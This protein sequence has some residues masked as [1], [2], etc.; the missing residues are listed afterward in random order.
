MQGSCALSPMEIELAFRKESSEL[1]GS[2]GRPV[3]RLIVIY[4]RRRVPQ[5]FYVDSGADIALIPKAVGDLLGLTLGSPQ[6]I[7]EI[8]GIGER[9]VPLVIRRLQLQIG[10]KVFPARVGWCLLEEAPPTLGPARL[11]PSLRDFIPS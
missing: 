2:I 9:G 7:R 8:K 1:F 11:L 4:R 5:L 10:S 6:E 3:A